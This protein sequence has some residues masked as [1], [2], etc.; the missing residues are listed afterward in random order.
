[1]ECTEEYIESAIK[2]IRTLLSDQKCI[3]EGFDSNTKWN[4]VISAVLVGFFSF[5]FC[6]EK[7]WKPFWN[8]IPETLQDLPDIVLQFTILGE[9]LCHC[10]GRN[11]LPYIC[12]VI[13]SSKGRKWSLSL[14][15][16]DVSISWVLLTSGTLLSWCH[17]QNRCFCM[18]VKWITSAATCNNVCNSVGEDV[19]SWLAI[20]RKKSNTFHWC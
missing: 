2:P 15:H 13:F 8:W 7:F 14:V 6:C 19:K 3:F 9:R 4:L 5:L 10:L 12:M 20:W 16:M 11:P 17:N 1:M 18:K